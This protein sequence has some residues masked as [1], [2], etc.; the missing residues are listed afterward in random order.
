VYKIKHVLTSRR[1]HGPGQ[2]R[3]RRRRGA[4]TPGD[5]GQQITSLQKARAFPDRAPHA[6]VRCWTLGVGLRKHGPQDIATVIFLQWQHRR[7]E[8]HLLS[9]RNIAANAE[10]MIQAIDLQP[11]DRALGVLPFFQASATTVTLWVPLTGR[12]I[13]DLSSRSAPGQGDR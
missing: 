2:T 9:H 8:G 4:G 13:R 6:W 5:I 12:R 1:L 3:S 11:R 10:S 7:A